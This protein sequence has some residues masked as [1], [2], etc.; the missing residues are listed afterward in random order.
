MRSWLRS[1]CIVAAGAAQAQD[2][3]FDCRGVMPDWS[4]HITGPTA[5]FTY[6]GTA[7]M[8]V[9]QFSRAERRVW[10]VAMTLV[11]TDYSSTAIVLI[12]ERSCNLG[13]DIIYEFEAQVLTQRQDMPVLLTGCCRGLDP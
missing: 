7:Q 13:E 3:S 5:S 8:D 9:P 6:I 12:H 11:S 4:A 10:P 1:L 2:A